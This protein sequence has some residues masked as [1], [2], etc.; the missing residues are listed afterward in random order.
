MPTR[1]IGDRYRVIEPLG[2]GGMGEVLRVE[3][4]HTKRHVALKMLK[5]QVAAEPIQ[6]ERFRREFT[7]LRGLDHPSLVR[8]LDGD[9]QGEA[10]Y[11]VFDL[12]EGVGLDRILADGPVPIKRAVHLA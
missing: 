9:P 11:L 3:D 12:V 6:L 2:E 5:A 4:L 8:L 7:V 10:P 1:I